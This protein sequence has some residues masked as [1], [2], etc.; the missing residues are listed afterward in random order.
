MA[1]FYL[2]AILYLS[3][4]YIRSGHGNATSILGRGCMLGCTCMRTKTQPEAFPY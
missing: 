2:S 3:V 1:I 4:G